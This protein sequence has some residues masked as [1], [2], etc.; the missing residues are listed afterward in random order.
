MESL[1]DLFLKNPFLI[2]LVIAGLVSLFNRKSSRGDNEQSNE[3]AQGENS[4]RSTVREVMKRMQEMADSLDPEVQQKEVQQKKA[5]TEQKQMQKQNEERSSE[6]QT[7][8]FEQHREA[9]YKRLQEQYESV[10]QSTDTNAETSIDMDST[11]YSGMQTARAAGG[12][13]SRKKVKVNLES[14]L[15]A[16]GLVESV[17]M[18]EILGPPRAR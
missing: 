9:Q 7:Y 3:S 8:S 6:S 17:V 10:N 5:A 18:S 12:R 14:R 15:K 1:I 2:F 4:G 11:I 16:D 13:A